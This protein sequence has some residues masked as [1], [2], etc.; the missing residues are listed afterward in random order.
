MST[1]AVI[2]GGLCGNITAM[3]L[4]KDGHTV[5]VFERDSDLPPAT[6]DQAWDDWERKG[7]AQFRLGHFFLPRFRHELQDELPEII[8][9]LRAVGAL[10]VNVL[11]DESS[12][13][14][15]EGDERFGLLTGRRP[16]VESEVARLAASTPGV[17]VRRGVAVNAL[18]MDDTDPTH[19]VGLR[20]DDGTEHRADLVI[21]ASG[22]RSSLPKLLTD[23]GRPA[24]I[25][26]KDDSGFVYY[27]RTYRSDDGSTPA[28]MGGAL[29]AYE[30]VSTLTLPADNG[31]WFC[32]FA[33]AADDK[34]MRAVRDPAVFEKT[35]AS[36]PMVAHWL[37]GEPLADDVKSMA[38]I[39]DRIRHFVI[40]GEPVATGVVAVADA[41]ACTN[42]SVGRGASMGVI[43]SVALRD[44]VREH[45]L[46]DGRAFA[47]AWH[48]R[49]EETVRP[50]YDD[51][52]TSD[53]HRLNQIRSQIDG[54]EAAPADDVVRAF[55]LLPRVLLTDLDLLH[56]FLDVA[57]LY[58][59]KEEVFADADLLER[60]LA[61]D[62]SE[63]M[64]GPTRSELEELL[65]ASV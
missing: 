46:D 29:Q 24:P 4:A 44:L 27:G 18:V 56:A 21:D 14:W 17:D 37:D 7:V 63:P 59:T 61:I 40:D 20:T 39:E 9:A 30:S 55:E 64:P 25:E 47:L 1:F 38:G 26:E 12:P 65:S 15:R 41:W 50:W 57:M 13:A 23:A 43:H 45:A 48:E 16:V 58:R 8:E 22:R 54:T 3:L 10:E 60:A 28:I 31:T 5:T 35:W 36:Y 2:G 51:T 53:R 32:G 62:D 19:V 6:T 49:T 11:G 33:A 42:P 34:A 52:L